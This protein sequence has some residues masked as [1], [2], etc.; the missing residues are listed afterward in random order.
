MSVLRNLALAAVFV[1][2][3]S[4]AFA[5]GSNTTPNGTST[6]PQGSATTPNATTASPQGSATT[7]N[8][9][10]ASQQGTAKPNTN[11]A[12]SKGASA[13]SKSAANTHHANRGHPTNRMASRSSGRRL[14]NR[15]VLITKRGRPSHGRLYNKS[16]LIKKRPQ[17][18][19]TRLYNRAPMT[20]NKVQPRTQPK[21]LEHGSQGA[22]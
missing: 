10:S 16:V 22:Q 1:G 18:S 7:P 13:G 21:S 4:V 15:G 8:N 14:Y 11:T 2:S 20:G 3:A 19:G 5:Q 17:P 9:A 12:A 6:P